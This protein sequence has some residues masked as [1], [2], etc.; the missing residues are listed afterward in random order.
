VFDELQ[1]YVGFGSADREALRGLH[2]CVQPEFERIAGVFYDR[3]LAHPGARRVLEGGESQVGALKVTLVHWMEGLFLGP[4]D[5]AYFERRCRIGRVHV[6]IRMP[7]HYM[8]GAM[9]VLR[10]EF[11]VIIDRAHT[12]DP[13]AAAVARSALNRIL[14]IELAI[15]LHTYRED[16]EAQRMAA[17][18][19]LTAG[20]SHEIRNPLNAAG[21]QLA[22]LE[23]RVR[24]MPAAEQA[25][26]LEP[27]VLVR[28]EIRRLNHLL[29][30]LLQYA[31]RRE[32]QRQPVEVGPLIDRVSQ[33]LGSDA[34]ARGVTITQQVE[35]GLTVMGDE[36]R[37]REVIINLVLN[38][39][40]ASERGGE[41][42]VGARALSPVEVELS[43]E[44]DGP[45]VPTDQREQIFQPFFTTK[46][47]GTGLG[48]AIVHAI[49]TQHRG[50][51]GLES[52]PGGGAVFRIRLSA[53]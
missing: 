40:E 53:R 12:A 19:I 52:P 24:R 41:V 38:A 11:E 36:S 3:I 18:G 9:N 46:A 35:P 44:D 2:P 33:L 47:Q 32:L 39:L 8:F 26:A 15:M 27:L 25:E 51:L 22:V 7:Q 42:R 23:R 30:D 4:W 34:E 14:D 29:E 49:V 13:R 16:L 50:S 45:G 20:L 43:V 6:R 17:V 37:L 5:Q 10:D 21:L 48:L 1:R 28:D 31:R